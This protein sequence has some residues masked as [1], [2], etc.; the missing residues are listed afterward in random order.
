MADIFDEA[1]DAEQNNRD[2][3]IRQIRERPK[4]KEIGFCLCC[5]EKISGKFCDSFCRDEYDLTLKIGKIEGRI[6]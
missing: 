2:F 4:L 3:L 1:S 5:N 6:R